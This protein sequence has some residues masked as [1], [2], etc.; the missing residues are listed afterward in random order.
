MSCFNIFGPVSFLF[1]HFAA[2]LYGVK[3]VQLSQLDIQSVNI[4][5]KEV[6]KFYLNVI[7]TSSC[8]SLQNV[9]RVEIGGTCSIHSTDHGMCLFQCGCLGNTSNFIVN[10]RKCVDERRFREGRSANSSVY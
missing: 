5:R 2:I 1:A 6:D 10:E 9:T 3:E 4:T 7:P 8:E